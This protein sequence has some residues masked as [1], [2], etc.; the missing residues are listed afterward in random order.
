MESIAIHPRHLLLALVSASTRQRQSCIADSSP[1]RFHPSLLTSCYR[2]TSIG[3]LKYMTSML[4]Y[5]LINNV[6]LANYRFV[7]LTANSPALCLKCDW[8]RR[9][10]LSIIVNVNDEHI[11]NFL[12]SRSKHG[13]V[14]NR[15]MII[16]CICVYYIVPF[17]LRIYQQDSYM[18]ETWRPLGL[19]L[20]DS[21]R[22]SLTPKKT[23]LGISCCS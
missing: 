2:H 7:A 6:E 5:Q 18:N 11:A 16:L 17:L 10:R 13:T 14:L 22:P 9:A 4:F 12:V 20:A 15:S 23:S 1:C 21:R 8:S 19:S 3:C